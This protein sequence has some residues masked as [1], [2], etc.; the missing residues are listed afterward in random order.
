MMRILHILSSRT[1]SGAENVVCQ[2][3]NMFKGEKDFDMAYCSPNGP[4]KEAL[5][6]RKVNFIP[7]SDLKI[8][9]IKRAIK[10][11]KPDVIHAHDMR[12]SFMAAMA[13]GSI[14][15]VSHIHNNAFNS[16]RI[17]LKSIAYYFAAKKAKK[18][19]W[20]SK[21][22]YEGYAF[23]KS[24]KDK[25]SILYNVID[26]KELFERVKQDSKHYDYDVVYVGRLTYQKNP[27]RLL[28]VLRLACEKK[29]DLKAAII[30]AGEM[31]EEIK[32]LCEELKLSDNVSLLGFQKNPLKMLKD[33]KVMIMTSRWEGTPMVALEAIALGIP[34]I[35]T[36][37]DGINELIC[38]GENGYLTEDNEKL[39]QYTVDLISDGQ[40]HKKM[41][42]KQLAYCAQINNTEKY[43]T[44]LRKIYQ[45]CVN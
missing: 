25:S 8:S 45:N 40:L 16:R 32:N 14:P 41:V 24:F 39:A 19:I 10:L 38:Q 28:H 5:E 44:V 9:E 43:K 35:S 21:S 29:P 7:L 15:L 34:I 37:A 36:P 26:Q 1:F 3:T 42:E 33:S 17:S 2:I 6:S 23:H 12:A 4:I 18:I 11:Y 20:V 31:F 22:S 30:G 13:C 27:Q